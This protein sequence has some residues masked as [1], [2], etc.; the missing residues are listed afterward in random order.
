MMG[1]SRPRKELVGYIDIWDPQ[2][3]GNPKGYGFHDKDVLLVA[4][5]QK[6][7]EEVFWYVAAGPD[8]PYPNVQ[9]ER[10]LMEGRVFLWMTW[11]IGATGFEY[12]C[13][14]IWKHNIRGRERWPK[15]PW[16]SY[17]WGKTNADGMLFYPGPGGR[18]VS[19]MRFE[20]I[21]DGIEDWE[22]L[23]ILRDCRDALAK[24]KPGMKKLLAEADELLDPKP[25]VYRSFTDFTKDPA[26][27]LRR[28][29]RAGD[30][31]TKIIAIVGHD[32]YRKTSTLRREA[33][34]KLQQKMLR[35]RHLRARRELGLDEK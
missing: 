3:G 28:R 2:I 14:N 26:V 31:V 21:R 17:G 16:N 15:V 11:G 30:L 12:Y 24:A 5:A 1:G 34:K 7:G 35:E 27:L 23:Y 20:T 18:P 13:Y 19:S 4:Q 10:V 29:E 32:A 22:T 9:L 6:R 8:P 33:V 25:V